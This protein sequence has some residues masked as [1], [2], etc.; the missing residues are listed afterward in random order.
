MQTGIQF[1]SFFSALKG[2]SY[3]GFDNSIK[4]TKFHHKR[5][6]LLSQ[7]YR[8]DCSVLIFSVNMLQGHQNLASI[9]WLKFVKV[10][11]PYFLG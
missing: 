9:P 8:S 1:W 2:Q 7:N 6:D 5:S 11:V 10:H 3:Q 4:N